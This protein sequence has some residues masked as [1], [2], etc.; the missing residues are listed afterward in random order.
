MAKF[1]AGD[2]VDVKLNAKST[3]YRGRRGIVQYVLKGD[4]IINCVLIGESGERADFLTEELDIVEKA[5]LLKG[6]R[7]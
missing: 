7:R 4:P 2:V 6:R 3:A 1:R 5:E